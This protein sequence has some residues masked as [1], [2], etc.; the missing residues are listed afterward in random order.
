[1]A[2]GLCL[3]SADAALRALVLP[4]NVYRIPPGQWLTVG[5]VIRQYHDRPVY[6]QVAEFAA[7][8]PMLVL[9]PTVLL[10]RYGAHTIPPWSPE[11]AYLWDES[12]PVPDTAEKLTRNGIGLFLVSKGGANQAYLSQSSFFRNEPNPALRPIWQDDEM[13][14][15]Q[16]IVPPKEAGP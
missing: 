7:G 1:L 2:L 15:F 14:L 4:L 5:G 10:N 13:V 16:I 12:A 3:I 9:G 8:R 6:R 11:V